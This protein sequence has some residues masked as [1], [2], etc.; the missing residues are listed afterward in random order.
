[1]HVSGAPLVI[2]GGV[3][4]CQTPW[5]RFGLAAAGD[6]ERATIPKVKA[7]MPDVRAVSMIPS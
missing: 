2:T 7:T 6:A 5:V 1:M 3:M 4:S